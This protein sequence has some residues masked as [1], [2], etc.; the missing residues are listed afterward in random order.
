MKFFLD[1]V[2]IINYQWNKKEKKNKILQNWLLVTASRTQTHLDFSY[3]CCYH[4]FW[5]CNSTMIC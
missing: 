1:I 5:L 3:M 4:I 2:D